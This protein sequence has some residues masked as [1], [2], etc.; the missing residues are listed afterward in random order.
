MRIVQRRATRV[1]GLE[2]VGTWEELWTKAPKAWRA[3]RD[4]ASEIQGRT[5]D[6]FV[7]VSL[8]ESDGVYRQVVGAEVADGVEAPGGM[9]AVEVPG[10]TYVEGPHAGPLEQIPESFGRIYAWAAEQDHAATALKLDVGYTVD[11]GE[12]EH[13]LF[14]RLAG[15]AGD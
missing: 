9:V 12:T 13:T 15:P 14:V 6:V 8:E 4:R 10:G 2:V 11:G 3:L 1:V 7:D 5:N